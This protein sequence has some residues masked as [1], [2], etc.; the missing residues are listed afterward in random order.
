MS[1]CAPLTVC[2]LHVGVH[3]N[4]CEGVG[5]HKSGMPAADYEMAC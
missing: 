5:V 1:V 3:D 4:A 2:V